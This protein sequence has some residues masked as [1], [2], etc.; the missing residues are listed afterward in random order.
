MGF[1]DK[2]KEMAQQVATQTKDMVDDVQGK[3]K[4][5]DLLE[6]VG[7]LVYLDRTGR[8]VAGTDAELARLVAELQALEAEGIEFTT[9]AVKPPPPPPAPPGSPLPPPPGP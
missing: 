1:L 7:R 9:V 2:A 5:E 4:A 6:D 3:R 8:S